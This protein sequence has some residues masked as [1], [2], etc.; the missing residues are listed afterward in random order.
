[1]LIVLRN[2][3]KPWR[4]TEKKKTERESLE[5]L[6]PGCPERQNVLASGFPQ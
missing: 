2:K 5:L 4:S 6:A 3:A 1:M